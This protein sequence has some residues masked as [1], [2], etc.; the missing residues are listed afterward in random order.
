MTIKVNVN[1]MSLPNLPSDYSH[2]MSFETQESMYNYFSSKILKRIQTN[3]KYDNMRPYIILPLRYQEVRSSYDYLSYNDY[4]QYENT[5]MKIYYYF[6]TDYEYVTETATKVYLQLDVWNTYYF[7]HS[8]LSSFVERTHVPRWTSDML[9]T[10]NFEDE[11]VD[12]GD[13]L[14]IE[15]PTEICDL[16]KSIVV[17]TSVPIG[18]IPSSSST[19]GGNDDLWK[20]GKISAKCFRFIKGMEGFGQYPYQDSGGYW[21]IGYGIAKFA[22]TELYNTLASQVPLDEEIGAKA[23]YELKNENYGKPILPTCNKIGITNQNQFDALV[24]LAYNSGVGSVTGDNTLMNAIAKDPTDEATIRPIWES[25]KITSNGVVLE[26]LKTLR[27]NQC[28]MFFGQDVEI[29]PISI[30]TGTGQYNGVVT[31]NN[32]DGWLP[33]DT[34]SSETGDLNG[35]KSYSNAYGDNWLCPVKGGTVSSIYGWRTHPIEGT[36]KFH[37]GTDIGI[38]Q[39]SDTVASKSGTISKT[40]Y[41]SS[42][43][44][45]IYLD[46][47]DGYRVKY[48]H[49]S[50]IDVE[51]GREVKRGDVVGKIGSTGSSTGAHSHWEI[52]RLSDNESTNP[53]P[54]MKVGDKV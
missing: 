39:G 51:V 36:L 21:T 54:I 32:G 33:D 6:I 22:N 15:E 43:G 28:N 38:A 11:G 7:Q 45:Y 53:A 13:M 47:Q 17:V 29:R 49:L 48:M 40:G 30:I 24:S 42:M 35:Y 44:N 18:Y 5:N 8:L 2:V 41:D 31:E 20:E 34:S 12:T 4:D 3:I 52:R 26:G 14:Q 16:N 50:S 1:L 46:T 23:S 10:N 37:H 25:F 19:G 9:P 27:K